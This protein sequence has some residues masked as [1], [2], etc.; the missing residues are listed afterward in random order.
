MKSKYPE[1]KE[2]DLKPGDT[3]VVHVRVGSVAC[4]RSGWGAASTP[5]FT[6]RKT[7]STGVVLR[8]YKHIN[9]V[10]VRFGKRTQFIRQSD[11]RYS[12]RRA[13]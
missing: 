4:G 9:A 7:E 11:S 3:V 6:A 8:V 12:I 5:Q 1:I 13:S 2:V 10:L